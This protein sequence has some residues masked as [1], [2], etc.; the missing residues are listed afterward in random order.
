MQRLGLF[1]PISARTSGR[2]RASNIHDVYY[3]E[4]G[5]PNGVPVLIVHGG[6]GGGSNPLMR[7][8]H[9]PQR[10]RI[11]L[12]DQ[13]GCGRSL[14]HA[15]LRQNTT[16]DLVDDIERIRKHL[17]IDRWQL[18][19]GS[20]GS[21]LSLIY[22][23]CH[24]DRVISLIL[25]GIFL[26]REREIS[27]F[28]QDG[29]NRL[30]PDAYEDFIA[31]VPEDRRHDVVRFYYS[32]LTS[33]DANVRLQAAKAWS[34]WEASTLA[35]N[36]GRDRSRPSPANDYA[37]AFAR[38]ECHYFVNKGFLSCDNWI[39]TGVQS[40]RNIPCLI[41]HGR[42]DVVTPL[43]NAWSLAKAWPEAELRVVNDAGHAMS[44]PGIVH[45]L[46]CGTRHFLAFD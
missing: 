23:I 40:I 14:P 43:H 17:G 3:E 19:G 12:F 37:L 44:E 18:F 20:W 42:Y 27:W 1:P 5:N 22:A 2:I 13:R 6:P 31:L 4:C 25:R 21:T 45:E 35:L 29:C 41:V 16:W 32:L 24:P 34:S 7:R 39:L 9:D 30:F 10:Y 8:F 36:S 38:I 26:L 11:I 46:V 15:D 33:S 28:Y